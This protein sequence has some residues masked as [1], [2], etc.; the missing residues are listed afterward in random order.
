MARHSSAAWLGVWGLWFGG[1]GVPAAQHDAVVAQLNQE[2][3]ERQRTESELQNEVS[4]LSTRLS[5]AQKQLERFERDAGQGAYDLALVTRE[6]DDAQALVEQL[7]GELERIADHL[8]QYAG[9][10]SEL[11]QSLSEVE[12]RVKELTEL[13]AEAQQS[14]EVL[15]DLALLSRDEVTAG[16]ITLELEGVVAVMALRAEFLMAGEQL[17]ARAQRIAQGV[18]QVVIPVQSRRLQVAYAEVAET[19]RAA[20]VMVQALMD[21]GLPAERLS[22]SVLPNDVEPDWVLLRVVRAP[23]PPEAATPEST[24]ASSP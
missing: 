11:A 22:T 18:A 24:P 21:S 4:A 7:R 14:A 20:L 17:S 6:R 15:R 5:E 19:Q 3:A 16:H 2:R 9:R 8:R 12:S 1:C 10:N 13:E 23:D